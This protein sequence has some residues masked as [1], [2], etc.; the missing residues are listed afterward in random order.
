MTPTG[1]GPTPSQRRGWP[2]PVPRIPRMASYHLMDAVRRQSRDH[3]QDGAE[4]EMPH[5]RCHSFLWAA[6]KQPNAQDRHGDEANEQPNAGHEYY[7]A[8]PKRT[9]QVG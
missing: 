1:A 4:N 3:P 2:T 5:Q 7:P 9:R 8:Q 6:E